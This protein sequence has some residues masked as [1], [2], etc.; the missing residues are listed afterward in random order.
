ML[1]LWISDD[2]WSLETNSDCIIP[3][4][5][6]SEVIVGAFAKLQKATVS[7]VWAVCPHGTS[8]LPLGRFS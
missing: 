6:P 3:F 8:G 2:K 7:F 4:Q 5:S 1:L